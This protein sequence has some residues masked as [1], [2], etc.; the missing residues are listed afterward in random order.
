MVDARGDGRDAEDWGLRDMASADVFAS[1]NGPSPFVY[2][3]VLVFIHLSYVVYCSFRTSPQIF[4]VSLDH[5]GVLPEGN[6]LLLP[7]AY[8]RSGV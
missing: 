5:N 6:S 1:L 8:E 4:L 2:C 7:L 3:I